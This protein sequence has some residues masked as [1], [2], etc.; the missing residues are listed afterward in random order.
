MTTA[1]IIGFVFAAM[2][3]IVSG[4]AAG[5]MLSDQGVAPAF[6]AWSRF[7]LAALILLP[8][9]GLQAGELRLLM[10]PRLWLRSALIAAGIFCI[11]SALKTEPMANVFGGFFIGP[12]VAFA[13]STIVLRE[14]AT[15]LRVVLLGISF[16][17]VLLVVRPGF[18]MSTGMGFAVLA[19]IF[20]GC[21]LVAT[22]WLAGGFR[23]RFLLLSQLLI[24]TLLLAP[25][26]AAS[27]PAL[28]PM[29]LPLIGWS[30]AG[31]AMGN[32]ILV[33]VNR[34]A[35]A[36][37]IAPL[38]YSQLVFAT[39]IGFVLF[40]EWPDLATISGLA[41]ILIAGVGSVILARRS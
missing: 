4:D 1:R 33:V 26:G 29:H 40:A 11:L 14:P 6:V 19:G 22:R 7:A 21:Y 31:S 41:I 10:D 39:V 34:H 3:L 18:G 30:A 23:P 24:G 27:W 5:K 28:D 8:L 2:F 15:P 38:I 25:V 35:P 17:G 9:A 16:A 36:N 12:I 32:L 13:L 20:H 37:V